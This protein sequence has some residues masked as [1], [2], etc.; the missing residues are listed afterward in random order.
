MPEIP[1]TAKKPE[2]RKD[3]SK[4][5]KDEAT[6]KNPVISFNGEDYEIRVEHVNTIGFMDLLDR[7][8]QGAFYAMP[9][10]I[11]KMIGDEAWARFVKSNLDPDLDDVPGSALEKFFDEANDAA[12]NSAA[13]SDS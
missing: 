8:D 9:A 10:V 12:G 4:A 11:R 2:D 13:S 6:G 7:L 5:A 1:D 3:K